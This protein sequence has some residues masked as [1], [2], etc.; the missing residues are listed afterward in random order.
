MRRIVVGSCM[1]AAASLAACNA[2]LGDD[3]PQVVGPSS[4]AEA[5]TAVDGAPQGAADG[6]ND[7]TTDGA[8]D[9]ATGNDSTIESGGGAGGDGGGGPVD[10]PPEGAVDDA[11]APCPTSAFFCDDFENGSGKWDSVS[12]TGATRI[13][14][15]GMNP[16]R[17]SQSLHVTASPDDAGVT[18]A[19]LLENFAGMTS[20]LLYA[21][22]YVYIQTRTELASLLLLEGPPVNDAI[23]VDVGATGAWQMT[24][25]FASGGDWLVPGPTSALVGAWHCLTWTVTIAADTSGRVAMVVD[26]LQAAQNGPSL[27]SAQDEYSAFALGASL[28]AGTGQLEVFYD[29]FALST[30]KLLCE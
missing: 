6:A 9:V 22:V 8:T 28:A 13:G 26:G 15:D 23:S 3:P 2:I 12:Q 30:Q 25:H 20:G 5:E 11:S 29:D 7:G 18:N 16:Y 14:I 19:Y 10:G 21:R 4:D 27:G 24:S 17:G 1:L